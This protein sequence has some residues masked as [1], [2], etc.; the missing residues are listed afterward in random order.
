MMVR[1]TWPKRP[2]EESGFNS[3]YKAPDYWPHANSSHCNPVKAQI[4]I[5]VAQGIPYH[6]L[7]LGP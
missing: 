2:Q 4:L 3:F 7:E 6:N 5:S 1:G